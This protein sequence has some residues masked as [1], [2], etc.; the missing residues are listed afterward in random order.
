MKISL[1]II[2]VISAS[3]IFSCT[4]PGNNKNVLSETHNV[5]SLSEAD[6]N[7]L[8]VELNKMFE[9][10]NNK[11]ACILDSG[12]NKRD[13]R[14]HLTYD[15]EYRSIRSKAIELDSLLTNYISSGHAT[16]EFLREYKKTTA[17]AAKKAQKTGLY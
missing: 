15:S 13:L 4:S 12:V 2:S 11:A 3:F 1:I 7:R 8:L 6:Y 14:V 9:E 17:R 16:A 5:D 10:V